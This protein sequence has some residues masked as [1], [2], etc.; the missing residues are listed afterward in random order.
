M[1][2]KITALFLMLASLAFTACPRNQIL[3]YTQ[4][5]LDV[6]TAAAPTIAKYLPAESALFNGA[7]VDAQTAVTAAKN[8]GPGAANV[9]TSAITAVISKVEDQI[10]G[11]D[12]VAIKD[13]GV[14]TEILQGLSGANIALHLL[15]DLLGLST[16]AATAH[17]VLGPRVDVID[18]FK[19]APVWG[20]RFKH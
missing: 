5:V 13:V 17:A 18:R 11:K 4:T 9:I 8:S 3:S 15:V 10:V 20:S 2:R 16:S 7:V 6:L 14:Q 1:K 12:V 19:A